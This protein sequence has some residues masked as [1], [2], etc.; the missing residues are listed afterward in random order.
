MKTYYPEFDEREY[1]ETILPLSVGDDRILAATG[2]GPPHPRTDLGADLSRKAADE[3][4]PFE[5]LTRDL[6]AAELDR[7]P[8]TIPGGLEVDQLSL[9]AAAVSCL[10]GRLHNLYLRVLV[11]DVNLRREMGELHGDTP[12]KRYDDYVDR[13][14]VDFHEGIERSYPVLPGLHQAVVEGAIS[15]FDEMLARLEADSASLGDLLR[16]PA[17]PRLIDVQATGD[18][19]GRG[20]TVMALEF[21]GSV[22]CVYK[23]RSVDGESA[24]A[25]LTDLLRERFRIDLASAP[26]LRRDGYGYVAWVASQ[27]LSTPEPWFVEKTGALGAVLYA[28]NARDMHTEN[29]AAT[30]EGPTPLDLETLLHPQRNDVGNP[31]EAPGHA[32][33]VL[34]ES[35]YGVGILP[36][37]ISRN[38]KAR[39]HID[40][41]FLGLGNQGPSPYQSISILK[42]FRDDMSLALESP[43]TP[44]AAPASVSLTETGVRALAEAYR[45]GFSRVYRTLMHHREEFAELVERAFSGA[46]LRYVHTPTVVYAQSLR[47]LTG[48]RALA[49]I[50][51][52]IALTKRI[53]IASKRVDPRLVV[54]E[55]EQ[56]ARRDIPSFACRVDDVAIST[57]SGETTGAELR[58]TPIAEF[59]RKLALLGDTDLRR[60]M[61]LI[62]AAFT[63]QFPDNHLPDPVQGANTRPSGSEDL[64]ALARRIGDDLIS[65]ALPDRF[66]HLPM[67]WIG[68]LASYTA[69]R[70]WPPGVLGYDLYTGRTGPA[71][72]LAALASLTDD[73]RYRSVP[74]QIFGT[75]ADILSG[76]RF[77]PR[78]ILAIG[79]GGFTGTAGLLWS[80]FEAGRLLEHSEWQDAARSSV[81]LVLDALTDLGEAD[82][83]SG[84]AGSLLALTAFAKDLPEVRAASHAAVSALPAIAAQA[85]EWGSGF[86]H[87]VAGLLYAAAT[88]PVE[89]SVRTAAADA[90]LPVLDGFFEAEI[91]DW[92]TRSDPTANWAT[93]WC[94]GSAGIALGLAAI[95]ASGHPVGNRL[96]AAITR[97]A[98]HGFGRNITLCHGDLGNLDVLR[99]LS[100]A[101]HDVD[102]QI[103]F[104][105]R[106]LTGSVINER[107]TAEH[108]R[109]SHTSSIMVGSSGVLL[110]ALRRLDPSL[111]RS[112]LLWGSTA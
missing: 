89:D 10:Q 111:V 8:L 43:T 103:G 109:Y 27:P 105:H 28:L 63:A 84:W 19:H 71:L 60:Q 76:G 25:H 33:E 13:W 34:A 32:Q 78:S 3:G 57:A 97:M 7:R 95:E 93:G 68:P 101:G 41:G 110:S 66:A 4:L 65:T 87:G 74:E 106:R 75:S 80:L 99:F 36:L 96:E 1:E 92:R 48:T 22:R 64:S 15:A 23:P 9:R 91:G 88:L 90:L 69:D 98:M 59:R 29:I 17:L 35:A 39:G 16:L 50:D 82:V 11:A 20:R 26:V 49:D 61:H 31:P 104:A 18:T 47:M 58:A 21:E 102:R 54:S 108:S 52:Y 14:G 12:E 51:T 46:I 79:P 62:G 37:V 94:H 38:D 112:P 70:P 107:L 53:G 86:A 72:A 55:A 100:A 40:A 24:Y 77:E 30:S 2:Y 67:T 45:N 85:E 81:P 5:S 6:A 56:L 73:R 83:V 42:A 44:S